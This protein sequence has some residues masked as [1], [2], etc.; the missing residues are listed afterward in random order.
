MTVDQANDMVRESL[1]IMLII[2][3]PVLGAAI[4]VGLIISILQ[5]VTQVQD[6]TLSFVPKLVSAVVV[7]AVAG[8]WMLSE[9]VDYLRAMLLSIPT[10]AGG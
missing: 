6:Q 7:M 1:V 5:A 10:A 2:S 3:A 9:L 4:I 8:P